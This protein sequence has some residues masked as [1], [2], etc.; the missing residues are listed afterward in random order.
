MDWTLPVDIGLRGSRSLAER[1]ADSRFVVIRSTGSE[2]PVE[3]YQHERHGRDH[4][5]P[6]YAEFLAPL[7]GSVRSR[8]GRPRPRLHPRGRDAG[9][10]PSGRTEH[11]AGG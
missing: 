3:W 5:A 10:G 1:L 2:P 6:I 9:S 7:V 4:L 8:S 11:G